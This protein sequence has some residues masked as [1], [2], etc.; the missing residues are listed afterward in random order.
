[1]PATTRNPA[2][3]RLRTLL[4]L[5]TL[6]GLTTPAL[7]ESVAEGRQALDQEK[8]EQALAIFQPLAEAGDPEAQFFLG[9]MYFAGQGVP[10]DHAKEAKWM[11]RAADQGF[12]WAQNMLGRM[13][14]TGRGVEQDDTQAY[15]WFSLAAAERTPTARDARE[16]LA[17]RMSDEQIDAA[18]RQ[19]SEWEA[20]EAPQAD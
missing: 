8:Y 3:P 5:L 16:R 1:M 2:K 20:I 10:R 15:M 7:A 6:L 11:Q 9:S 12:G 19:A 13:Y 14:S 4:A 18:R 17:E